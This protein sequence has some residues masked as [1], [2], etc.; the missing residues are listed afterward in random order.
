M[1]RQF[2]VLRLFSQSPQGTNTRPSDAEKIHLND[3]LRNK[4]IQL[5]QN[6][7]EINYYRLQHNRNQIQC[8][9]YIVYDNFW[10]KFEIDSKSYFIP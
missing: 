7:L 1:Y 4:W 2:K 6:G 5:S 9:Q 3:H 10:H 8:V